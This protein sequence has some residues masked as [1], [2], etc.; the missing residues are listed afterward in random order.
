MFN[1]AKPIFAKGKSEELNVYA[2][3][4]TTVDS[5]VGTEL[6]LT[7]ASFYQ[8]FVNGKF[9]GFGPARTAKGY[10]RMDVLPLEKYAIEGKNEIVIGVAG[11]YCRSF[12]GIFQPS[13]LRAEVVFGDEVI[14]CTGRNFDCYL[15]E[16]HV[17]KTE[18]Y[19]A[20]RHFSEV[21]DYT[22][23]KSNCDES[24]RAEIE[25]LPDT[26]TILS[27]TASYPYYEDV[28]CKEALVAGHITTDETVTPKKE[29]YSFAL[30]DFWQGFDYDEVE[31]HPYAWV[32][33]LAQH[34][35][36]FDVELPLT[37]GDGE[38]AI[39][40][41]EKVEAGFLK[42]SAK[43]TATADVV[44]AFSEY[45]P[46]KTF[47]FANM[48]AHN[49]CEVK[50]GEGDTLDWMSREPYV[51]RYAIVALK[52]GAITLNGFGVKRFEGDV[53]KVAIPELENPVLRDIYRAAV[54]TYAHNVVDVYMDCPSRE[55]AGWLC[56][57]YFTGKTEHFLFGTTYVEDA[58]LENYRLYKNEDKMI[59]EGAIPMCFPSDIKDNGE[60]IPQWTMWYILEVEDYLTNRNTS[61]DKELFRDSIFGLLDFYARYENSD[62]LLEDLPSWNFVEWSRANQWVFNV[63]YPTNFLYAQVLEAAYKLYGN[64]DFKKKC[65]KVRKAAIEQSFDG[66]LFR[67][68][69]VRDESGKLTLCGDISEICQYYAILF[70]GIDMTEAKYAELLRLVREVFGAIR[71]EDMPE[72]E[73]INA[74][75]GV[76]LR[77]EALLKIEEYDLVLDDVENFFGNM[78]RLTG[79]LW[80]NRSVHGSLDH[81][82]ASYAAAAMMKA[83]ARK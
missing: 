21:W 79:T 62:G 29:N 46:D 1:L 49:V 11:Y 59:P 27:R 48:Q 3:F 80:E 58:F 73:V 14:A 37:L 54:R 51:L 9:V 81:G 78:E 32:Q 31:Y 39:F 18:R 35:E 69:A 61:V 34:P 12:N 13:F 43:A 83:L 4:K 33:T 30:D 5:L 19:S 47:Q 26:L 7:A 56:D 57:S 8:V 45:I 16:S 24:Y 65:A 53:S 76:Y 64:E 2:V 68:H 67:D 15:P 50:I 42:L 44:I 74:F 41:L 17:Q 38:Y 75:I 55:R 70:A 71:K 52:S 28:M 23:G 72:I 63:N 82:F 77:L 10:A 6:K 60:M 40:D 22:N 20:Q 36:K 66:K 25:I